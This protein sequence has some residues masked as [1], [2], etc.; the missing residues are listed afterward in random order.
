VT[1]A[2]AR[3]ELTDVVGEAMERL[4]IPGV[5]VALLH[6][7]EEQVAGFGVTSLAHPL[8]VD[9]DTLFQIGSITKT[10]TA[11]V[12]MRLIEAGR[13]STRRCAPTSP[14]CAWPMRRPPPGSPS[15]IC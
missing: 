5:S 4:G 13:L 7:G 11:T 8:P 3:H 12:L 6:A 9:A 10:V 2:L 14:I 15:A 1:A